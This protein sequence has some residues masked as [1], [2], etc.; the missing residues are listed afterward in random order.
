MNI[1]TSISNADG[2]NFGGYLAVPESGSGPGIVVIQEIF[3]IND[4]LKGT[5]DAIA[6]HGYVALVPDLFWRIEEGISLS[7]S[8]EDMARAFVLY[9]LFDPERA[10]V[11]I[12][13]AL[14]TI[15]SLPQHEGATSHSKVGCVGFCLGG[16][17]AWL[18]ATRTDVDCSVSYYGVGIENF[19]GEASQVTGPT[20]LH[21]AEEDGFVPPEAQQQLTA[22]AAE[23]DLVTAYTYPGCD[24]A[25]ATPGRDSYNADATKISVERSLA[26]FEKVLKG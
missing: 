15:R 3:G 12:Q 17:L 10:V 7:Y 19:L 23:H 26:M 9:G 21:I 8:D 6:D 22:M 1:N 14:D 5:A 11:D 24:H 16:L 13:G 20:I 2:E 4:F 18:T 25:F